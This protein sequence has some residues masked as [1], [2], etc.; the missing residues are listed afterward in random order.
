MLS[1]GSW[2]IFLSTILMWPT[3][4]ATKSSNSIQLKTVLRY[5]TTARRSPN[6]SSFVSRTV[7]Q[8]DPFENVA[9]QPLRECRY[10]RKSGSKGSACVCVLDVVNLR[11]RSRDAD[12]LRNSVTP[13]DT[14]TAFNRAIMDRPH[15][16]EERLWVQMEILWWKTE[17]VCVCLRVCSCSG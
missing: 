5:S 9:H 17:R 12:L 16:S 8:T 4:I 2:S 14:L 1:V 11:A 6:S 13:I 7:V 15:V 3:F 10:Q